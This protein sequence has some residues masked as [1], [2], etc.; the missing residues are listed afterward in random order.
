MIKKLRASPL[1]KK[2]LSLRPYTASPINVDLERVIVNKP[3]GS[4][5][6]LYSNLETE[7]WNL[8]IKYQRS[9]SMHCHPNKKT[10]LLVVDGRALFSSINESWELMPMDAIVIDQ[11]VFHSTQSI[12]KDGLIVFEFEPPPMKHDLVRLEDKYGRTEKG[13]EDIDRMGLGDDCIR[14]FDAYGQPKNI[15]NIN[16]QIKNLYSK[17]D[18]LESN[19]RSLAIVTSGIIRSELDEPLYKPP[20]V[21]TMEEL[22]DTAHSFENVSAMFISQDNVK[23]HNF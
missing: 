1:D 7:V 23:T 11:G 5:Y 19:G 21:L 3:W 18:I 13:Y 2:Y 12:S 22:R 14:L 16:V 6:L 15:C 9:T 17:N 10:V 8:S 20:H 4:E